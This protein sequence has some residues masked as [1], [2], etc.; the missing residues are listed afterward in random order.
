MRYF[1]FAAL[2]FAVLRAGFFAAAF[3]TVRFFFFIAIG[4]ELPLAF[5][6]TR[7]AP[8]NE[9]KYERVVSIVQIAR[10]A[11]SACM[12]AMHRERKRFIDDCDNH[13][14]TYKSHSHAR[15]NRRAAPY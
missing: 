5:R 7:L 9:R 1:R 12:L 15:R 11:Q 2:R 8:R 3:F 6:L 13:P 10:R 4:I 14:Y